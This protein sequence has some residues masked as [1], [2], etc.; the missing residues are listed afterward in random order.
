M[1]VDLRE[2][3]PN[4]LRDF[5]IDPIDETAVARLKASI[6]EDGFWGGVVC[7]R[8]NG[9]IEI[10]AGHHRVVAAIQAGITE[11]DLFVAENMDDLAL[12]RIYARENA[13]QRGTTN[14][15]AR[16]GSVAA[17]VQVGA[18]RLLTWDVSTIIE[19]WPDLTLKAV[20]TLRG[21]LLTDKGLGALF[22]DAVLHG[23]PGV[24]TK[25]ILEDLASLKKSGGY[26]RIIGQVRAQIVAEEEAAERAAEEARAK[27][28]R[29]RA[30]QERART[31]AERARAE[32]E[33][34]A[35]EEEAAK[36]EAAAARAEKAAAK[37]EQ[38]AAKAGEEEVIFDFR[39]VAAH[40]KNSH[41]IEVFRNKV[42]SE[43]IRPFL[44]VD[45]QAAVAEAL[46]QL[47]EET[48]QELT[49]LFIRENLTAMAMQ[50]RG[51]RRKIEQ[52]ERERILAAD[53]QARCK[54][55]QEHLGGALRQLYGY[56]QRLTEHLGSRPEGMGV[57]IRP[58]LRED[59]RRA[60]MIFDRMAAALWGETEV[61][62]NPPVA[63]LP[64]K[65][66]TEGDG[67]NG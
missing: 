35:R 55:L 34:H 20:E 54:D 25:T 32:T 6:E 19:T 48:G 64:E 61:A 56:G 17:A 12:A 31:E 15:T 42:T 23:V 67:D 22:V 51:A 66:T 41:H 11:A 60:T 18:Y 24:N 45:Q 33:A 37:A 5:E 28:A 49:G 39:G 7:R 3:K 46:F 44:P 26:A 38:A 1:I 21:Q 52:E 29:A 14:G 47:A 16:A 58:S 63:A 2:L 59:V 8:Y 10:G 13:T 57:S 65:A 53:W 4:P 36:A 27:E 62:D 30:E 50:V 40:L 9:H 43:G